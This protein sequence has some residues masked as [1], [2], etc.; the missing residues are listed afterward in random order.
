MAGISH[1]TTHKAQPLTAPTLTDAEVASTQ[2]ALPGDAPEAA[3]GRTAARISKRFMPIT[4]LFGG[5][6]GD[7]AEILGKGVLEIGTVK[8]ELTGS[9]H[10]YLGTYDTLAD[11]QQ[12]CIQHVHT[13]QSGTLASIKNPSTWTITPV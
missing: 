2:K 4:S 8:F 3:S 6:S 1:S 13:Q 7:N 12:A 9:T 5:T 11:A 10:G